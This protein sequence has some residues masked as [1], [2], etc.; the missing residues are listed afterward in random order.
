MREPFFEV[1]DLRFTYQPHSDRAQAV[2]AL[3]GLSCV[4]GR[5]EYVGVVGGNGS[6]KSTLAKHLNGL[7]LPTSGQVRVA[8]VD[9]RAPEGAWA[10]RRRVGMIFQNP[11]NQLV[12]TMVE[13]DVAF[14]PENL[15]VPSAEIRRRVEA[16]LDAV[17]MAAFRRHA[18]HLLSGGQK[19]RVAIAGVLAMRPESIVL[20]EPTTMIDPQGRAEVLEVVRMLNRCD[21][22]T[23]VL[24]SHAMED[25]NDVERIIA[26][27]A[28]RIV[29]DG[30]AGRIFDRLAEA[31][32][33]PLVPPPIAALE[34][35]LR[36]DGVALPP[37]I[38]TIE[39]L[40]EALAGP[41]GPRGPGRATR[42]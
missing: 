7:L 12:A 14:G 38:H 4:I 27:D 36:H 42:A 15:G 23:I 24:I 2:V 16:A 21:G 32:L 8:G 19:Q 20:D 28:G 40:V 37:G 1:E 18:P 3:D 22:I 26:L 17:G 31:P 30:P 5:G 10:A 25:L 34:R 9:T 11:D 35:A 6:G 29:L 41:R 13:E 33:G 39:G